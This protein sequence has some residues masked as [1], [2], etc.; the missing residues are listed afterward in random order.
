MG[1]S[2]APALARGWML[3]AFSAARKDS[4]LAGH[5]ASLG[6]LLAPLDFWLAGVRA[7]Q[8]VNL[9]PVM[10]S[11]TREMALA[12]VRRLWDEPVLRDNLMPLLGMP[13]GS[14]LLT[15]AFAG[16]QADLLDLDRWVLTTGRSRAAQ[17]R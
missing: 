13:G 9:W 3:L 10:D 7:R 8:A 17:A 5:A 11:D 14:R 12:H 4:R 6:Y 1:V 16:R 15:N 2:D